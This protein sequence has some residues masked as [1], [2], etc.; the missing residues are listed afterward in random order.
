MTP[1]SPLTSPG[2]LRVP[3]TLNYKYDPPRPVELLHLGQSY[4]FPTALS[5][6]L[7]VAPATPAKSHAPPK[8]AIEP[9]QEHQFAGGP[10]PAFAALSAADDLA[11]GIATSRT[12]LDPGHVFDKCAFMRHAKD[13][14]G[15]DYD[16]PLWHLSVLCTTFFED[17]DAIAHEISKNH[18]SYSVAETQALY[19]RKLADRDR[20]IGPPRC[21][22][23]HGAGCAACS[24]CPFLA[25]GKTPLH[26]PGPVTATVNSL[27]T[28][29]T[30]PWSSKAMNVIFSNIPHR[31]TLYGYDL[32]RGEITVAG[33]PGGLGKSSLAIGISNSIV[34]GRELLG[35]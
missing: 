8:I 24:T 6:L 29:Q 13:T 10:D 19:E 22:T 21:A 34:V 23:I 14:G 2:I 20:G 1:D 26:L 35:E 16:N 27:S 15:A 31:G 12:P 4:D 33:S 3:G 7:L 30:S 32:V 5:V 11:A 18:P 17:G 28:S 9:G 25:E